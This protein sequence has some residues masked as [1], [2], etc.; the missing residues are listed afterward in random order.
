MGVT[1][2]SG[3]QIQQSSFPGRHIDCR[4]DANDGQAPVMRRSLG[5]AD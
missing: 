2:H 4:L 3:E 1:T 5:G